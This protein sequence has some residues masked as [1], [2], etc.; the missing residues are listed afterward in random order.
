MAWSFKK[1]VLVARSSTEV[2]Y[3]DLVH[4]TIELLWLQSL[5]YEL[6]I[7]HFVPTLLCDSISVV[8]LAHNTIIHACTK[9]I[10]LDIHFVS[11]KVMAN[12]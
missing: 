1:Q 9:H 3:G 6:M 4:T 10:E 7:D 8:L 11:E 5:L 2:E 12:L